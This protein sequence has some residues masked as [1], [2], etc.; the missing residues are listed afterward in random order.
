MVVADEPAARSVEERVH[1]SFELWAAGQVVARKGGNPYGLT[2]GDVCRVLGLDGC[3]EKGRPERGTYGRSAS[4]TQPMRKFRGCF[5]E[6][7]RRAFGFFFQ[8]A[9]AIDGKVVR[10]LN[11]FLVAAD[12]S[13]RVVSKVRLPAFGRANLVVGGKWVGFVPGNVPL[14]D[15]LRVDTSSMSVTRTTPKSGYGDCRF[16]PGAGA[17]AWFCVRKL[18]GGLVRHL[19]MDAATSRQFELPELDR[20]LRKYDSMAKWDGKRLLVARQKGAGWDV[21]SWQPGEKKWT[22]DE[23]SGRPTG[24]VRQPDDDGAAAVYAA[25]VFAEDLTSARLVTRARLGG[26]WGFRSRGHWVG[27]TLYV[28]ADDGMWAFDTAAE[29]WTTWKIDRISAHHGLFRVGDTVVVGDYMLHRG[30]NELRR[31]PPNLNATWVGSHALIHKDLCP[32]GEVC[33]P[34]TDQPERAFADVVI[35]QPNVEKLPRAHAIRPD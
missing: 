12:P 1:D 2:C 17:R 16:L 8:E 5:C 7:D 19:L 23:K 20:E 25:G 29:K 28:P 35:W 3:Y 34:L 22:P 26:F 30:S 6:A 11:D 32:T 10:R 18:E 9:A 15:F 21:L 4:C 33:K 31:L 27:K 13:T 14:K 24:G